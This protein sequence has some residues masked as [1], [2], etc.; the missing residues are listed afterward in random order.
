MPNYRF[1]TDNGGSQYVDLDLPNDMSARV[2][3]RRAFSEA[4]HDGLADGGRGELTFQVQQAK[5]IV[6]R[7]HIA[8]QSTDLDA[9]VDD[10]AEDAPNL[11]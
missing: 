4:A 10:W 1:T 2:E 5:R 11:S 3:G 9:P 6:Y 7:G 8:F